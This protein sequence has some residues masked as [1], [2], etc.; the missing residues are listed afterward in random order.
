MRDNNNPSYNFV[1]TTDWMFV[2]PRDKG[3]Y[4]GDDHKIA[5][6]STGMVGLLLTKSPEE[7]EFLERVGPSTILAAVGKPWASK[8]TKWKI[9]VP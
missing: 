2:S 1:M 9:I 4:F 7:S 6:N 8:N 5:V 3:D